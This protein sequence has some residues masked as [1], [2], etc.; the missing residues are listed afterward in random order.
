M[1]SSKLQTLKQKQT[2]RLAKQLPER[3][4]PVQ[5]DWGTGGNSA[6]ILFSD[7]KYSPGS[8]I[9]CA[10]P[11]CI[12]FSPSE[13]ELDIFTDFPADRD[14]VVCPTGA[15]TWPQEDYSP[16]VDGGLCISCGL[17]VSR[18][19]V[20]AIYM[21]QEGAHVNDEPN[22]HF[23]IHDVPA[24]QAV[25]DATARAFGRVTET[26]VYLTE[27]DAVLTG[28]LTKFKE[29]ARDQSAQF[30]NL[31]ARNLFITC[32]V[33][34]AIRRRGDTN[35][36]MDMVLGPPGIES[37]TGEVELGAGVLDSPRNIL[38]NVAVLVSR[39]EV[40]KKRIVPVIVSLSLPN[41]RS[42]YWQ[43]IKDIRNVLDIKINSITIG[44]LV[45]LVWNRKY[46]V[47]ETGEELYIDVASSFLQPKL[48]QFLGRKL[49]IVKGYPGFLESEK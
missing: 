36:R 25:T 10:N 4:E 46:I 13:L 21:D 32:G 43:V 34:A 31:L 6:V 15:I 27:S 5:I 1:E 48:E 18:C 47:I 39:Y 28:F 40:S 17:C 35:I 45:I 41:Q 2:G 22:E 3:I 11:L 8:C 30:P 42:E 19:P 29:V 14:E 49:N 38:D 33:G 24:T 23:Q 7:G 44:A 37:G 26:G 16:V 12:E 20:R 9:R